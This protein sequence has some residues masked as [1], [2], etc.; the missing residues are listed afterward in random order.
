MENQKV[1]VSEII[2]NASFFWKP[3]GITVMMICI[4]LTD[5]FDL[6]IPS[7]VAGA[8]VADWGITRSEVQPF[9]MA[10]LLGMAIGSILFGWIG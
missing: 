2:D 7:Y 5:G 9:M 8:M 6:F 4:M 10:G 3:F 1:D